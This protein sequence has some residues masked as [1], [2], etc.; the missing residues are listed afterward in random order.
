LSLLFSITSYLATNL[1]NILAI[2]VIITSSAKSALTG[3]HIW[4]PKAKEGPTPVSAL[5]HSS[6]MVTAG[7]FLLIKFS[8]LLSYS[9]QGLN[10]I[11]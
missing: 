11:L 6:T 3:I 7:C 9:S 2:L 1:L 4:L 10:I 8:P 5:L